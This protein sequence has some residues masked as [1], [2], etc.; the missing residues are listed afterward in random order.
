MDGFIGSENIKR[1]RK[2]LREATDGAR[3]RAS[4]ITGQAHDVDANAVALRGGQT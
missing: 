2:L 3:L 1:Y 4:S